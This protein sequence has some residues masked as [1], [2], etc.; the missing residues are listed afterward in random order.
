MCV[1]STDD[2]RERALNSGAIGFLAKPLTAKDLV[3][4]AIEQLRK[5]LARA[6]GQVLVLL[7]AGA[8]ARRDRA[9]ASTRRGGRA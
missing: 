7:P 8:G 6:R 5:Y 2:A 1:I 3:D 4:K 9:R